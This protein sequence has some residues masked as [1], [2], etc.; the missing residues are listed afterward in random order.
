M[1]FQNIPRALL[2]VANV[3]MLKR[4]K[5]L[6]AE[7][8]MMEEKQR[9][10]FQDQKLWNLEQ[11]TIMLTTVFYQKAWSEGWGS[12]A[13]V[14]S[15]AHSISC[16]PRCLHSTTSRWRWRVKPVTTAAVAAARQRAVT[17]AAT[18]M[19]R[20]RRATGKNAGLQWHGCCR[21]CDKTHFGSSPSMPGLSAVDSIDLEVLSWNPTDLSCM[22]HRTMFATPT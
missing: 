18:V 8:E 9:P 21:C 2:E 3:S 7:N 5:R 1:R 19:K 15:Y 22:H 20:R 16:I 4:W 17:A 10:G 13:F 11:V 6:P 12:S 14:H